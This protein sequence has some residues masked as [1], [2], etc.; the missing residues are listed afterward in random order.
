[1]YD[2]DHDLS[3]VTIELNDVEGHAKHWRMANKIY[4]VR[5]IISI[6]CILP[7]THPPTTAL[8]ESIGDHQNNT[9]VG[10]TV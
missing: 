9:A 10:L 5:N 1:M 3:G 2:L 8:L 7:L 6:D 4:Q